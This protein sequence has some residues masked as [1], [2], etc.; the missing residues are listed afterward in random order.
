[1]SR[2]FKMLGLAIVTTFAMATIS[3]TVA[4]A[5][6][7]QA[8]GSPARFHAANTNN[9]VFHFGIA[10]NLSCNSATFS[11][12]EFVNLPTEAV[13]LIPSY[14]KCTYLGVSGIALNLNGCAFLF[15]QPTAET[16]ST[17]RSSMGIECPAGKEIRFGAIGCELTIGSQAG[18]STV[19]YQ[20]LEDGTAAIGFHIGNMTYT[21]KGICNGEAGLHHDGSL[22]GSAVVTAEDEL[23]ES[24]GVSIH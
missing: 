23:G 8:T 20:N 13:T 24:V 14:S 5:S 21:S 9:H 12:A 10:G 11:G 6:E 19:E 7:F 15:T 2:L 4:Q 22:T 16:T 17:H 18:L 3:A 1:M